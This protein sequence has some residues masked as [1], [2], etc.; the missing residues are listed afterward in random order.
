MFESNDGSALEIEGKRIATLSLPSGLPPRCSYTSARAQQPLDY[1]AV[2]T[3][4]AEG[5]LPPDVGVTAN[6]REVTD[7]VCPAICGPT[8]RWGRSYEAR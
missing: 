8:V 4:T 7:A 5:V 1:R 2:E 6:M 3:V